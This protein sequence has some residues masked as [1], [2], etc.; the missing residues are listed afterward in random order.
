MSSLTDT[1]TNL[2]GELTSTAIQEAEYLADIAEEMS[3]T[4]ELPHIVVR[5]AQALKPV[6]ESYIEK[7]KM[8]LT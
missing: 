2:D 3:Y 1:F 4:E 5:F 8:E 6:V 7:L